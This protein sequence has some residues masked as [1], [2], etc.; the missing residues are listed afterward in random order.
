MHCLCQGPGCHLL[1]FALGCFCSL[2][3]FCVLLEEENED[4]S[5][6]V[7][8][9]RSQELGSPLLIAPSERS[10]PSLLSPW[11]PATFPSSPC[12]LLSVSIS[13]ARPHFESPNPVDSGSV[14]LCCSSWWRLS[15]GRLPGS[16]T[17]G[18]PA[19]RVVS[20]LCLGLQ[21]VANPS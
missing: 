16:A 7:A 3:A 21:F 11:S 2:K 13:A 5:L 12:L 18:V 9:Q 8:S 17:F 6:P 4:G 20:W 14:L 10:S 19:R 1:R 15:G